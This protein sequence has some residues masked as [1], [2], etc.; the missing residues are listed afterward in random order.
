MKKVALFSK[1]DRQVLFGQ[2]AAKM[3]MNPSHDYEMHKEET[4]LVLGKN[5]DVQRFFHL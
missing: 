1:E 4:M 5:E 2:T 3:N